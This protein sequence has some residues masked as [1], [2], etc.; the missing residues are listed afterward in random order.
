MF[1]SNCGAENPKKICATC[2]VKQGKTHKYCKWCGSELA[3]N[4][5]VCF[6]CNKKVKENKFIMCLMSVFEIISS[7]LFVVIF[8]ASFNYFSKGVIIGG[9][10]LLLFG[11]IGLFIALPFVRKF[12]EKKIKFI[13]KIPVRLGVIVAVFVVVYAFVYPYANNQVANTEKQTQY[14]EAIAIME[15]EPLAAKE[16]F[17]ELGDYNDSLV[18][19]QEVNE[20]IY[21]KLGEA[22]NND[23]VT[24]EDIAAVEEY[25]DSLPENFDDSLDFIKEFKYKKGIWLINNHFYAM[26]KY[27]YED[28]AGYKD[29]NELMKNPVYELMGNRYTCS[30]SVSLGYEMYVQAQL[31]SFENN[32]N[33]SFE[34]RYIIGHSTLTGML[35]GDFGLDNDTTLTY[36]CYE[37]N[38]KI[39]VGDDELTQIKSKDGKIVSFVYKENLYEIA[40]VE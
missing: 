1:C 6:Q 40:T 5:S 26:A 4:V 23:F 7:I 39:Y 20:Y 18:K 37:E 13:S 11:L 28:I 38:G 27:V 24:E 35:G 9:L 21:K 33:Y 29:V 12:Y 36:R 31:L 22:I 14:D 30:S 15:S 19:S 34:A 16:K 25:V 10:L 32:I 2:G 8:I 3:E 17:I